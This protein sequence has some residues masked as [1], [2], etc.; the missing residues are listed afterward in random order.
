MFGGQ[1]VNG[2]ITLVCFRVSPVGPQTHPMIISQY[3]N[4]KL[5]YTQ[6]LTESLHWFFDLCSEGYYGRKGQAPTMKPGK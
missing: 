5:E 6:Q 1:L 4:K 3:Q 2:G